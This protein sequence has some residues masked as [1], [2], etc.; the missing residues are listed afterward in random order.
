MGVDLLCIRGLVCLA[1][2]GGVAVAQ[3]PLTHAQDLMR[4]GEDI[5]LRE[6]TKMVLALF[7]DLP[8]AA[9]DR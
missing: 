5:V 2:G 9:G 4:K 8:P 1:F 3:T 6:G 7:K